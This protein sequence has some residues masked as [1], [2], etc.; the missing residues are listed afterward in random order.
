M[1][2]RSLA[3]LATAAALMGGCGASDAERGSAPASA[4]PAERM[5]GS[6]HEAAVALGNAFRTGLR[7]LSVMS[8]AVG[9]TGDVGQP[10]PTG[11]IDRVRC[12]RH[13]ARWR[14]GVRWLDLLGHRHATEYV[15]A[16]AHR[17]CV[18]ATAAP[19]LGDTYDVTTRAPAENPLS[20]LA[21]GSDRR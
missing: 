8:G 7:E 19:I 17:G 5:P 15:I 2:A 10:V 11:A 14:C 21:L 3:L 13:D 1:R 9:E 4:A 6:A 12:A 18:D 16:R 20:E